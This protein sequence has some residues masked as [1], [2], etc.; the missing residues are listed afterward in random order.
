MRD[1]ERQ[2]QEVLGWLRANITPIKTPTTGSYGMKHVVEDLLGRYVSNG[3]LVA[4]ALMAGYPW[5]GPF[6]PN[7]TFGM[8]KKD[9]DRVQA[10]RQEQARSAAGR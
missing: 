7:A 3:E 2:V 9:V 5:K 10:A 4:A 8:R 6:G 1:A